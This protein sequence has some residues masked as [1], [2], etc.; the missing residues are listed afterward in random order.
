MLCVIDSKPCP[1]G[2]I[3]MGM[4]DSRVPPK[5]RCMKEKDMY[6]KSNTTSFSSNEDW[7]PRTRLTLSE[8]KK[9]KAKLEKSC[10]FGKIVAL[11]GQ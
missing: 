9:D 4:D 2:T 10:D 8:A 6:E 7:N 3:Y 5:A 1:L 11:L